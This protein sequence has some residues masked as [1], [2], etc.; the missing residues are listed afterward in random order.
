MSR[1][2]PSWPNRVAGAGGVLAIIA[3]LFTFG[4]GINSQLNTLQA[5]LDRNC[6]VLATVEADVRYVIA[7]TAPRDPFNGR[8][9]QRIFRNVAP[10]LCGG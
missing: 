9:L 8:T 1:P 10:E 2:S 7:Q 3:T 4:L 5:G 6:R